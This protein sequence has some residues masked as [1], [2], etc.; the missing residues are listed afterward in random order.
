MGQRNMLCAHQML[1]LEIDQG[2]IQHL[3][4]EPCILRSLIDLHNA[5]IHR[6]FSCSGST[7][8]LDLRHLPDHHDRNILYSNPYNGLQHRHP[9]LGGSAPNSHNPYMFPSSSRR[10]G[11][12]P[13]NHGTSEHF[14]SSSSHGMP[15]VNFDEHGRSNHLMDSSRSCKRKNA[16][17]FPVGMMEV[18]PPFGAPEYR[19]IGGL[20]ISEGGSHRS[21]RSRSSTINLQLDSVLAHCNNQIVQGNHMGQSFLPANS[22]WVEQLGNNSGDI[23]SSSWRFTPPLPYL[24]GRSVN[25]GPLEVGS[26]NGQGY[27]DPVSSRNSGALLHPL[28]MHHHCAHHAS[29]NQSMRGGH[30]FSYNAQVPIPSYRHSANHLHLGMLTSSRDGLEISGSRNP[31]I[32]PSSE[33]QIYR[34]HQ[35]MLQTPQEDISGRM[36]LLSSEDVAML[37]FS[38]FYG[39]GNFID[40]HRDMRLDIDDMSYEELLALEERIGDVNTGLSEESIANC[41]KTRLHSSLISSTPGQ[42]EGM[43]QEENVTCIICQVEYEENEKIGTLVCGHDYHA[44][45]I[46]QW[47]LVKNVCPICKA[48]V[49]SMDKKERC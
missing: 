41:L 31:T 11:P 37:D 47:L 12:V 2:Q 49:L 42:P 6:V 3:N 44:V 48:S 22:I 17:G 4:P 29:T 8:G 15:D 21:V 38:S 34:P 24:H 23:G 40:Q 32:S 28:S 36:R 1:D 14:T 20:S 18:I 30:S 25:G 7:P 43:D 19:G 9:D 10:I 33:D 39:A 27:Q 35:R 46:R 16:E 13:L 26:M 5:N 45:C